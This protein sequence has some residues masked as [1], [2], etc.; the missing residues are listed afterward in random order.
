MKL[1][2]NSAYVTIAYT[3]HDNMTLAQNKPVVHGMKLRA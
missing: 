2:Y 1:E 3:N